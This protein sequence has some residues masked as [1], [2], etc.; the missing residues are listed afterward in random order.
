[1]SRRYRTIVVDPPWPYKRKWGNP[2]NNG[3]KGGDPIPLPYEEMSL[4][5][6]AALPV[7]DLVHPDGA[8]LYLWTTN[9]FLHDAFHVVDAWGFSYSQL[10][11]WAKT[12]MGKGPG[13]AFAQNAE[14]F[15][16]CRHRL[17]ITNVR[18]ESV[19]FNWKRTGK[20]SK[21]PDGFTALIEEVSPGPYVELF[22]R[23]KQARQGW[24]YWGDES[25]GT[26][27]LVGA[28]EKR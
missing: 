16:F 19:W 10:G 8:H 15:L 11:I 27:E 24:D 2:A 9:R 13:G 14:F 23:A 3:F 18:Q 6:I 22:S 5:E 12:P 1:V 17:P 21:K 7:E 20:H 26:A 25:L 4:E 28:G